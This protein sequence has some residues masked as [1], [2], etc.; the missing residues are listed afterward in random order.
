[1][2]FSHTPN[3]RTEPLCKRAIWLI[4]NLMLVGYFFFVVWKLMH[5]D[6]FSVE[7]Y[8]YTYVVE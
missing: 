4:E 7:I 8:P 6:T 5:R 2:K 3:F 1:M